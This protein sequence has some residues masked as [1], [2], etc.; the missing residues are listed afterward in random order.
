MNVI[1]HQTISINL[2]A[3]YLFEVIKGLNKP[4]IIFVFIQKLSDGLYFA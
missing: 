3:A 1:A 2:A 4:V